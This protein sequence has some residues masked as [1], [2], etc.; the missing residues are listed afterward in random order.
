MSGGRPVGPRSN[1][2]VLG[3]VMNLF[4][5]NQS[6]LYPVCLIVAASSVDARGGLQ[7]GPDSTFQART[8]DGR[9]ITGRIVSFGD[10]E[11]TL[12]IKGGKKES[13]KFDRLVRIARETVVGIPAGENSQAVL[14]GDGDR[15]IRA[16][17][18][19]ATE[20]VLEVRSEALGKL[21]IPLG[22]VLG[23]ILAVPG[24]PTDLDRL[25]ERIRTEPRQSEVVWLANGDRVA[26]SFLGM[27]ERS[28]RFQRDQKPVE[29]DRG[30]VVALGFDPKLLDYP[31]PKEAFLEASLVDGTRIGLTRIRLV[32]GNIEA[33]SRSG[34]AIRFP[35][36]ELARLQGR[37]ESVV[38]LSERPPA[39][40]QY[41]EYV[42]PTL[43]FR[44]DRT[45]D[46]HPIRLGG[47]TF[48]RGI[49][50]QSRTFLAY[51]IEPGDRR[52]QATIG[53]DERAGPLGSVVFRVF[54]DRRER[55]QSPAMTDHD[56]PKTLDIDLDGGK[57]LI[58]ATEFGERGNVCD[59]ADWAEARII[60][61]GPETIEESKNRT[62]P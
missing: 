4:K 46:G 62:S 9:E 56:P 35:V 5:K 33:T 43:P 3:K 49:G 20:T 59:L 8:I 48:D 39:R 58:L 60:R 34:L 16:S 13:L 23:L 37:S 38:Y 28:I 22:N 52:F 10:H 7:D 25:I 11:V 47:Q 6:I 15:L 57:I 24:R 40:A 51:R 42:G 12:V 2:A 53:V 50:T 17:I 45:V 36:S 26:G 19:G 41:E 14:L 44:V 31:R 18:R 54:V 30:G 21:D 29:I 27:D 1:Q 61:Q 55:F 32:E